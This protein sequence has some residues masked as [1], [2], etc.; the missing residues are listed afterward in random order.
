MNVNR[1]ISSYGG[2]GD[3][4]FSAPTNAQRIA[5]CHY[6]LLVAIAAAIYREEG[7]EGTLA[8]F[9]HG[10]RLRYSWVDSTLRVERFSPGG[11][12]GMDWFCADR[13]CQAAE[14][15]EST[16]NGSDAMVHLIPYN[17]KLANQAA[18]LAQALACRNVRLL[19]QLEEVG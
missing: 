9:A 5:R 8:R 14:L 16:W 17:K 19:R 11:T 7:N 2:W 6:I 1:K 10:F 13:F 3:P 18:A 15:L 12:S 4:D